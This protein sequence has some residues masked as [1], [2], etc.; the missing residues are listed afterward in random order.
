VLVAVSAMS[1]SPAPAQ[2]P[3]DT[4]P[5]SA[6]PAP[7]LPTTTTADPARRAALEGEIAALEN[8]LSDLEGAIPQKEAGVQQAEQTVADFDALLVTNQ[9]AI[10][11]NV[12]A[13]VAPEEARKELVLTLY[14]GGSTELRSFSD[15]A[16][17][18]EFSNDSLRVEELFAAAEEGARARLAELDAEAEGLAVERQGLQ[19][20]REQAA[21]NA[22]AARNDLVATRALRDETETQLERA[23][24]DLKSLLALSARAPLSGAADYPIRPAIGVKID[25]SFDARPQTGLTKADIVYDIIVEGGITRFLAMFQS[26]D[27]SRIGPVRSARTSDISIMAGYNRPIFAYSG[28]ND[29][30]LAAVRVSPM[31]SLTEASAPRAFVRD[32]GRFAPQNL[33]TSTEALYGAA[34]GDAGVPNPQ[35]VFRPPGEASVLG[36]PA[37]SVTIN[38]GFE[39]VTYQWNGSSWDRFTNGDPTEDTTA[40]QVS[41]QNVIVQF[42][43]YGVSPADTQSP[44]ALTVGQGVAWVLTDGKVIEARWA[45]GIATSPVQFLDAANQQ[46]PMTPG[47][48]WIEMPQPGSASVS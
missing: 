36:R 47:Q 19:A 48:T 44:D 22:E 3:G 26:Q 23:R 39:T 30:V 28:G 34:P 43:N 38:I 27:A 14:I 10:D 24:A 42:I 13:H 9:A 40:G 20:Q 15:F 18:G 33:Y 12:A 31:V 37:S 41:P 6:A 29:G 45:R 21:V 35:L 8:Q 32:E 46:V 16:R 25:N 2:V 11:A 7:T 1:A 17:N 4:T 5:P